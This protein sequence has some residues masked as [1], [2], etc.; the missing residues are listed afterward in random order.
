MLQ[1]EKLQCQRL[2]N[3]FKESI[4][5][6]NMLQRRVAE[7]VKSTAPLPTQQQPQSGNVDDLIEWGVS[8]RMFY[9]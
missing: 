9:V 5:R 8:E 7:R 6:Y 2:T 3:E 4:R 1:Q